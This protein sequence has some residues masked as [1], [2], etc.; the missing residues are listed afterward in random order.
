MKKLTEKVHHE[1]V[2]WVKRDTNEVANEQNKTPI[3]GFP[4]IPIVYSRH[5]CVH[6]CGL[7]KLHPFDAA[8]GRNISKVPWF[9]LP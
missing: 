1:E 9:L 4:K 7:E 2:V 5:Y 3:D 6:F 8:K